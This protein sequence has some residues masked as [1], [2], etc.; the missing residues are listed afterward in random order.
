MV[1]RVVHTIF[2]SK[3]GLWLKGLFIPFL[4]IKKGYGSKGVH[5]ISVSKKKV[6]AQRYPQD[7][8]SFFLVNV[9][10]GINQG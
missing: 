4:S 7:M 2:V 6:M 9:P 8:G 5:T 10:Q 1:K 3:K